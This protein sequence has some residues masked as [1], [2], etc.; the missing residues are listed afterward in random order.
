VSFSY[1]KAKVL[2]KV[3]FHLHQGEFV[4]LVGQNGAG[5]T[6]ILKLILGIERPDSG[7]IELFGENAP[8]AQDK[9]GYVPQYASFD[10]AFPIS[11]RE[12]VKMG[13]LHALS[14]KYTAEDKNAV[15]E[16][17]E[18]AGI[19]D[20]ADRPYNALS[21]GERRRTLVARALASKPLTL[22]LDEPTANMDIESE[23]RLFRVLG[24]LKGNTTILIVTHDRDFVSPLVDRVLCMESGSVVQHEISEEKAGR[25]IF[26]NAS[27]PG[28][29]CL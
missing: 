22:I 13:R 19:A 20:L 7:T 4:S 3:S 2:D 23:D 9:I 17:L 10:K 27:I 28:D 6:T 18:R 12:V 15:I 11:V 16:A 14:K 29:A 1:D 25:R 26:H 5:K 8:R 21:G 24:S